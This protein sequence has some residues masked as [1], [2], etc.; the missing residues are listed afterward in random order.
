[1]AC[2][3]HALLGRH[4][5]CLQGP[6][7]G[8]HCGLEAPTATAGAALL[9]GQASSTGAFEHAPSRQPTLQHHVLRMGGGGEAGGR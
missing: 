5:E 7:R 9:R 2:A 4:R 1:M 8:K 3:H 6:N